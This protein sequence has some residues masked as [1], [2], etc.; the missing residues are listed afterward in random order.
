MTLE[1]EQNNYNDILLNPGQLKQVVKA[2]SKNMKHKHD[3][4]EY[5]DTQELAYEINDFFSYSEVIEMVNQQHKDCWMIADLIKGL[6]DSD[7]DQRI[8]VADHLV[9]FLLDGNDR[10]TDKLNE[11]VLILYENGLYSIVCRQLKIELE[12]YILSDCDDINKLC[13]EI[14]HLINLVYLMV[15]PLRQLDYFKNKKVHMDVSVIQ[16][17]FIFLTH[18]NEDHYDVIPIR[19]VLLLTWKC[20]LILFGDSDT[21][22]QIKENLQNQSSH[23]NSNTLSKSNATDLYNYLDSMTERYPGFDT[24]SVLPKNLPSQLVV[25]TSE[26]TV[27]AMGLNTATT[28]MELPYQT[29]NQH[30]TN[31]SS[32]NKKKA[33]S[34]TDIPLD[35]SDTSMTMDSNN[36]EE[37]SSMVLPLLKEGPS[38]PYSVI[39]AGNIYLS[40][41]RISRS[42][43]QIIDQREKT[44]HKW[45]RFQEEKNNNKKKHHHHL[46]DSFQSTK[47]K[48]DQ[49]NLEA[50]TAILDTFEEF[51]KSMVPHLQNL[52]SVLLKL[53]LAI[54]PVSKIESPVTNDVDIED[55]DKKRNDEIISKS[56]SAILL[57]LLKWSKLSHVLKFEYISQLL[58]DSGCILLIMK[59]M[60]LQDMA[61]L[62][63]S[64]TDLPNYRLYK[65]KVN[66]QEEKV[67]V[68][69]EESSLYTNERNM[70][71][72]INLLRVLQKLTKW[73]PQRIMLMVQYKSSAIFRKIL[74]I[75]HPVM[76]VCT[77]KILK[78]QVAYQSKKW[79][80]NNMKIISA[81]YLKCKTSLNDDW[82]YKPNLE[83]DLING[84]EEEI[85][86]RLLS[87]L[88]HG[89]RYLPEL[90]PPFD[91]EYYKNGFDQIPVNGNDIDEGFDSDDFELDPTFVTN[92]EIGMDEEDLIP[93]RKSKRDTF[94]TLIIDCDAIT[95]EDESIAL[96]DEPVILDDDINNNELDESS[97]MIHDND[98]D[99]YSTTTTYHDVEDEIKSIYLEELQLEFSDDNSIH[100]T[101]TL[102]S[103]ITLYSQDDDNELGSAIADKLTKIEHNTLQRWFTTKECHVMT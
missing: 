23:F 73:K 38:V 66:K 14:N 85:N 74:K 102:E 2:L 43:Q 42:H 9:Q 65:P 76:E 56:V 103:N 20:M 50:T 25:S 69:E 52:I 10:T 8:E 33:S 32:F 28:S 47:N 13:L 19:K 12:K 55:V 53:L 26:S 61:G 58:V 17:L 51:Y 60:G 97:S 81:I 36:N 62:V 95:L 5:K 7:L 67:E 93:H 31:G 96:D 40:N 11:N 83:E 45:Q 59:I 22:N 91:D 6:N 3:S 80:S 71:W 89:E 39:E 54:I 87:Q 21:F 29:F 30:M 72:V 46:D 78:S 35:D 79:R 82:I 44:I 77:L 94:D 27:N 37:C 100:T 64:Q 24:N 49:H 15:E 34:H 48:N 4:Y 16:A 86:V 68:D 92:Y 1:E 41:L 18:L 75:S 88:Y 63:A 101:T 84:K 57:C 99:S 98:D 90:I 70:F